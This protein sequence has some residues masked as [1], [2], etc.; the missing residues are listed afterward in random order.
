MSLAFS[1]H[2]CCS[3]TITDAVFSVNSR[4][5]NKL[6]YRYLNLLSE[7]TRIIFSKG[8]DKRFTLYVNFKHKGKIFNKNLK[9]QS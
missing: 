4:D 1:I 2:Q 9:E 8:M 3:V 7:V 6:T 5:T